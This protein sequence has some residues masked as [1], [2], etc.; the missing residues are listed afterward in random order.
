MKYFAAFLKM[1]DTVKSQDLRPDHI[2]FLDETDRAGKIFARGRFTDGAGGLVV[3]V[4]ETLEE[5]TRIAQG[6]PYIAS[7]ARTLDIHEWDMKTGAGSGS[8]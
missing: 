5:A 2:R 4:A 6:D 7:G 3:Y 8:R 1:Q